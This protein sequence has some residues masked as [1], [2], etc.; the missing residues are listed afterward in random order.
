MKS[1]G[2]IYA[3][4]GSAALF[5]APSTASAT[6]SNP[7]ANPP[8]NAVQP[9]PATAPAASD[10]PDSE[11][12]DIVVTAQKRSE[13]SQRVPITIAAFTAPMLAQAN[14]SSVV[15]L[16]RIVPTLRL[17][18]T[19]GGVGTRYVI[20][21]VGSFGNSALEPSVAA[22]VD[23]IYV[24][25]PASLIASFLD[26]AGVEVLSGPQGTI[27]G[28]NAS[29]GA[30]S[31]HT[32]SPTNELSAKINAQAET[33]ELYK[34]DS[35]VNVPVSDNVAF[36]LAALGQNFGGYWH[37]TTTGRRFGGVD[38]RALRLSMK[39]DITPSLTWI[40]KADAQRVFGNGYINYQLDPAT[41]TPTTLANI[42]AK[43]NGIV[44]DLN[45]FDRNNNVASDPAH[46]NDTIWG[47]TSDLAYNF[48][49]GYTV[50]LLQGYHEWNAN[51]SEADAGGLSVFTN[52]RTVLYNSKSHSDELQLISPT[53]KLLGGHL[54][55]LAG[56]YYFNEDLHITYQNN[57]SKAGGFCEKFI[58]M[59]PAKAALYSA[60]VNGPEQDLFDVRFTQRTES[61]A[62]YGQT[63]LEVVPTV[64]LTLGARWTRDIKNGTYKSVQA[65]AA[66]SLFGVAEDTP[67]L[68]YAQNKVTYRANLA[69]TPVNDVMLYAT[70]STGFKSGGFNSGSAT[71]V[72]GQ[73]RLFQPETVKNYEIGWKTRFFDRKLTFNTT[74]YRMDINGY[75]ER[76]ATP[77][78][79]VILR[80]A[81]N[82]RNQGVDLD[83]IV[84][85]DRHFS[86][87]VTV[88]YLDSKFLSY[89]GAPVPVYQTGTQDLTGQPAT[90]APKWSVSTGAQVGYNVAGTS[91]RWQL[92]GDVSY[93]SSQ[94]MG[95]QIDES[96][97]TLQPAYTLLGARFTLY[98]KDDKWSLALFGRNLT[99]KGYCTGRV[100][101]P[102][103]SAIGLRYVGGTAIRCT[104]GAPRTI[105]IAASM[106][107]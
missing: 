74:I 33:G 44:P 84:A 23:G 18:S 2:L 47:V 82:L 34:L 29:A 36:R 13:S 42:T 86:T 43:N 5:A 62:A 58:G 28:R 54:S 27:F 81:G 48:G 10:T 22:F 55:F 20:R 89:P 52:N 88:A 21:G 94:F 8:V 49:G 68:Y 106:N 46:I 25:R 72:L 37:N 14:V 69:W 83:V 39:A 101:N 78:G 80:N 19:P 6:E 79:G 65:D 91:L 56:L 85:P 67:N 60:C 66:A 12:P 71:T 57:I 75:Q 24:P 87:N 35:F 53:D 50:R 96:P 61:L 41:L 32:G 59:A 45:L 73:L 17:G 105:G 38:T 107:F 76:A 3:L 11:V 7:P 100:Y 30:I 77:V 97:L 1:T 70:F 93:T 103:D 64:N 4:L 98:G 63:T 95:S 92:R 90:Y 99:D 40:V 51:E 31:V 16:P 102:L 9:D 26:I 15:D 104:V